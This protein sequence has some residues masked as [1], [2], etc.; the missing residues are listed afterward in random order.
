[1]PITTGFTTRASAEKGEGHIHSEK[2]HRCVE[3]V[4]AKGG[5]YE[6]HAVCTF[7]IGYN[8]SVNPEHQTPGP[9]SSRDT[10][11]FKRRKERQES[12]KMEISYAAVLKFDEPI[13]RVLKEHMCWGHACAGGGKG[14]GS[15]D[16]VPLPKGK[17]SEAH[18]KELGL[19]PGKY[20]NIEGVG[21]MGKSHEE[22][23]K[24]PASSAS[25]NADTS[26][27][28]IARDKK[29]NASHLE[30][31]QAAK[32]HAEAV[33]Q[34]EKLGNTKEVAHHKEKAKFHREKAKGLK[35]A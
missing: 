2:W 12:Q 5:G 24:G 10:R 14:K 35:P 26:S 20:K 4:K 33:K 23:K 3:K 21:I 1:M 19:K 34:H 17:V 16:K 32:A 27:N 31:N 11:R 7:S 29:K 9:H 25:L 18:Q 15:G 6:P 30:H 8:E 13:V 22:L 28:T